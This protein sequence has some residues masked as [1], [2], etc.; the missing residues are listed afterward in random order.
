MEIK[1]ERVHINVDGKTM[2]GYL[3]RP[4]DGTPRPGVVVFM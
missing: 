3:A 2:G 1:T 4:V